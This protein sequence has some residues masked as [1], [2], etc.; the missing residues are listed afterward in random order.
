MA[1]KDDSNNQIVGEITSSAKRR[2]DNVDD[3]V[4]WDFER[5]KG[6]DGL[7]V[8]V[9]NE[10]ELR[11]NPI[12]KQMNDDARKPTTAIT[13]QLIRKPIIKIT[14]H[15]ED[16]SK[17]IIL[18]ANNDDH[19]PATVIPVPIK[20]PIIKITFDADENDKKIPPTS[21]HQP[22]VYINSPL[23]HPATK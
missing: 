20:K 11:P 18:K 22:I 14:F 10:Q 1:N 15:D 19:Q 23:I 7:P 12:E 17:P 3:E 8:C 16:K 13:G 21:R 5:A 2:Y 6:L 4:E 9:A